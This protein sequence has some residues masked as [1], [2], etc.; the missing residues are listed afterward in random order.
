MNNSNR[1]LL[2]LFDNEVMSPRAI[3][4]EVDVLHQLLYKVERL[5]NIAIAHEVIDLNKYKVINLRS[6][7]KK[8]ICKK[9]LKPFV[10]L[11]NK[12]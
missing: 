6:S 11:N 4:R 12:N 5:D 10:F 3:E 1:D 2:V 9:A 8:I 7:V